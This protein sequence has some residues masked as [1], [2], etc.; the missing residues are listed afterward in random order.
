VRRAG[1]TGGVDEQG[2]C[3]FGAEGAGLVIV[4]GFECVEQCGDEG[5]WPVGLEVVVGVRDEVQ[6]VGAGLEAVARCPAM[7]NHPEVVEYCLQPLASERLSDALQQELAVLPGN[8]AALA[9]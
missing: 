8:S 6:A 9:N 3:W 1:G 2:C 5:V 4:A 7:E